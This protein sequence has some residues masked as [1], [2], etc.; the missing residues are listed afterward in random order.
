MRNLRTLRAVCLTLS[1]G[2]AAACGDDEAVPFAT[3]AIPADAATDI[4]LGLPDS[5]PT[6]QDMGAIADTGADTG[7]S[8]PTCQ[9]G[10]QCVS[11]FCVPGPDGRRVCADLCRSDENCPEGWECRPVLTPDLTQYLFVLRHDGFNVCPVIPTV[12]VAVDLIDASRSEPR[13]DVPGLFNRGL[14]RR[15]YMY[16]CGYRR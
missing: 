2:L 15:L 12:I 13:I 4:G 5:S 1:L 3:D 11:G 9:D 16:R 14:P 7:P 6:P 8:D 10:S